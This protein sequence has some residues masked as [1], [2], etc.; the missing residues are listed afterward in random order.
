MWSS[1][2]A[3][4]C[5]SS[6]AWPS[7][8]KIPVSGGSELL[9]GLTATGTYVLTCTGASGSTVQ[10]SVTINV[11]A[12][13]VPRAITTVSLVNTSGATQT[14]PV[15]TLGHAFKAGDVPSGN[16]VGAKRADGSVVTLQV[17]KKAT[18]ADGSVRHAILTARLA[19]LG[20]SSSEILTLYTQPDSPAGS[21]ITPGNLPASFDAQVSLNLGG[22]VYSASAKELLAS[23]TPKVWLSGPEVSEWIV[24]GPVKAGGIAHPHLTAYFHIRAY[25]GSPITKVRVDAVVENN[26][27]FKAGATSFTYVPTVTVGGTTIYNNGGSNL[28]H[29]HHT[30]WH[31]VGWWNNT[32]SNIFVKPDTRYLRDSKAVPNYASVTPQESVLNGYTQSVVPLTVANLR[33]DWSPGGAHAQLGLMPEWYASYVMSD[34]DIRAYNAVLAND[35]A[36]GAFS[37]HYRDENTGAPVSIDTY[38]NIS[39]QDASSMSTPTGSNPYFHEGEHAPLLGYLGYLLTGDYYYLEE[40]QFLANWRMLNSSAGSRNFKDGIFTGGNRDMSWAMRTL[41]AAAAITPDDSVALKSYFTNKLNNNINDRAVKWSLPMTNTLGAIKDDVYPVG[42]YAPWQ[43]DFF[44][45]VMN[46]TAELG[47]NSSNALSLR[48]WVNKWPTGRMG[49]GDNGQASGYCPYYSAL[50]NFGDDSSDRGIITPGG[51]YRTFTELYQ[52]KFLAESGQACP[53]SGQMRVGYDVNSYD[54]YS[55]TLQAAL[56]MA[57]DSRV[58]TQATWDKFVSI[59]PSDYSRGGTWGIVPRPGGNATV[60]N[61]TLVAN[62]SQVVSGGGTSLEWS[63]S[64]AT[65]CTAP[66]TTSQATSGKQAISNITSATTYTLTCTGPGGS[67]AQT[68]SVTINNASSDDPVDLTPPT[69]FDTAGASGGGGAIGPWEG[70]CLLAGGLFFVRRRSATSGRAISDGSFQHSTTLC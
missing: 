67:N 9:N 12:S 47:F 46:W 26:W 13:A 19:S 41:A 70:L 14:N 6:G 40:L 8:S 38:P 62:P 58:A 2:N 35:S 51:V 16:T 29:Y 66:W 56:A 4:S 36:G 54:Y 59:A 22:T 21:P 69:S 15:V 20:G 49:Q 31:Q 11:G 55:N 24:G 60:P 48:N 23:T 37:Y 42:Y 10:A 5:I 52:F 64:N 18:H 1:T 61:V 53:D 57:V 34:G 28:T 39:E 63:T 17:D 44:V 32:D 68:V 50:Y 7:A 43:M 65:N 27:T 30:R 45:T 25:A 3:T 33:S